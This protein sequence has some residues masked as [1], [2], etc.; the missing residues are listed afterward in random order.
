MNMK[1]ISLFLLPILIISAAGLI[2]FGMLQIRNEQEKMTDDL[3]R[4]S[5]TVAESIA[6][7]S[8][9]LFLRYDEREAVRLVETFQQRERLQGCVLYDSTGRL[10]VMTDR[11]EGWQKTP[12][13][14]LQDVLTGKDPFTGMMPFDDRTAHVY[15]MPVLDDAKAVIG[16]VE[17]VYDT[18]YLYPI[19]AS[20]WRRLAILLAIMVVC[21]V[22]TMLLI[23]HRLFTLPIRNLTDWFARF[24]KG[25]IDGGH[26]IAGTDELGKLAREVEQVALSLRVARKSMSKEADIRLKKEDRWTEARL[27]NLI[28]AKLGINTFFVVSNREPFVHVMDPRT[29]KPRCVR[30]ASGVVTAIDPILRASGGTWIAHGSG[31]ADRQFVNSRNKLGVPPG[32]DRYILR[33]VWLSK[34]EE[35]GY[36]YGFSNEGIWPLCHMTHTR[37]IFRD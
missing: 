34:H 8:R 16:I 26:P 10:L 37:P 35:D 3:R 28:H 11:I 33:R 5:K 30:P 25:E 9:S 7:S 6:A 24:Q 17:I 2:L 20:S 19:L 13:P 12:K 22:A 14:Y 32:E 4:K 21:I 23:Q 27:R 36:Y 15:S 1:R 29:K 18:S 31:E